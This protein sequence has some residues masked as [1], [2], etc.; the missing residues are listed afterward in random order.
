MN[1]TPVVIGV[2]SNTEDRSYLMEQAIL[3][4]CEL[5]THASVS[6]VYQSPAVNGDGTTYDNAVVAGNSALT[7]EELEAKLK[8][9]EE[10]A[11]RDNIARL[12]HRVPL[13]L[14]LVIWNRQI[15]RPKD[16]EQHYFNIGYRELLANGAFQYGV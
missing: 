16:F 14:D 15:V 11:G 8:E 5:L 3:K 12:E 13:D 6:A 2:G 9:M 1:E 10:E 4:L 7:R